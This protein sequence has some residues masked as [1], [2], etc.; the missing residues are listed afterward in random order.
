[1]REVPSRS[2]VCDCRKAAAHADWFCKRGVL[3]TRKFRPVKLLVRRARVR[4]EVLRV[5]GRCELT[6]PGDP[7]ESLRR[8]LDP[9]LAVVTFGGELADHLIGAARGRARDVARRKIDGRPNR[10][11]VH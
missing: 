9:I 5:S 2:V 10:I 1:M 7:L 6:F 4:S 8:T 11:L 3:T